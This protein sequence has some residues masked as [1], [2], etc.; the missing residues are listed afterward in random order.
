LWVPEESPELA[1]DKPHSSGGVQVDTL[2]N[3]IKQAGT[4][5]SAYLLTDKE[6]SNIADGIAEREYRD[7]VQGIVE[8]LKRAIKDKEIEDSDGVHDWL[9]DTIDGHH[10][11]IYTACA[12][13]IV[14]QSRNDGAYF[15]QFGDEGA[16]K[17][18]A[19]NWSALAYC[20]LEADVMEEIGDID[21]LFAEEEEDED[22]TEAPA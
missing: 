16:V 2:L 1:A 13:E 12:Q 21:D 20:A 17:D 7:T 9:H 19:I 5:T 22:E 11:V 15:D 4:D 8:D 6:I 10:D 3:Y 14:R 18:G